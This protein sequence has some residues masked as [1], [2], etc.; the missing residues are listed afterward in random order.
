MKNRRA[1]ERQNV[2]VPVE[3]VGGEGVTRNLN[4]EGAFFVTPTPPAVGSTISFAVP[5]ADLTKLGLS[6]CCEGIVI[7]TESCGEAGQI[8]VAVRITSVVF[9]SFTNWT[10]KRAE[11]NGWH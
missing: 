9:D 6:A 3:F 2:Q 8:G 5:L 1:S 7:R 10:S 4:A 11:E